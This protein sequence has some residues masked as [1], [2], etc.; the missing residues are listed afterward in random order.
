MLAGEAVYWIH[1][2]DFMG[3]IV[4][5]VGTGL[6]VIE[7]LAWWLLTALAAWDGY[8]LCV[9]DGVGFA[10]ALIWWC[11]AVG[12]VYCIGSLLIGGGNSGNGP[13]LFR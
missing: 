1:I 7:C 11:W 6:V 3:G 2:G 5:G 12:A 9:A 10:A 8:F 13:G 4:R